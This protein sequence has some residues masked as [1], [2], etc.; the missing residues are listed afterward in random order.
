MIPSEWLEPGA[1]LPVTAETVATLL[2][3]VKAC[4]FTQGRAAGLE[5]ER[6]AFEAWVTEGDD[7][8]F[9]KQRAIARGNTGQYLLMQTAVAWNVWQARA[10]LSP[11]SSDAGKD[12]A[13]ELDAKRYNY[14]RMKVCGI[15]SKGFDFVNL[16][17]MPANWARG[18]IA[19]HFDEAID[20]A[21][22]A[23]GEGK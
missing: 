4:T 23:Q 18:S 15:G 22:A 11:I 2:A 14:L 16:P 8:P 9:M 7:D 3:A 17:P 19:Q 10:A 20:A 21:I 1:V 12:D 13:L 5:E 6:A